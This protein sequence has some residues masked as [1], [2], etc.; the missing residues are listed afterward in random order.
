MQKSILMATTAMLREEKVMMRTTILNLIGGSTKRW[1]VCQG[2]VGY[3]TSH[4]IDIQITEEA[5]FFTVDV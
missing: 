2:G 1:V 5:Q 4:Q 3:G